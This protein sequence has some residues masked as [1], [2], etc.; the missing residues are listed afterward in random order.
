MIDLRIS[1]LFETP[2]WRWFHAFCV[3]LKGGKNARRQHRA[4][5]AIESCPQAVEYLL[6][7]IDITKRLVSVGVIFPWARRAV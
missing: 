7:T 2:Q 4:N 1:E 6:L 3:E 5:Y